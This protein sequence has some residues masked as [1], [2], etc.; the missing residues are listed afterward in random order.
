M[1]ADMPQHN[2]VAESLNR[3]LMEHV[4]AMQHQAGL[5]ATL[6][7]EA[8]NYAVWLKN[9]TSTK[10]LGNTMPYER[11]YRQ[12]PNLANLPDWGQ[13]VWVY[14]KGS[15]L[16]ARA[17]QAQWIGFD[18]DSTHVHRIYW[19]G[20]NKISVERDIKFVP[21]TVIVQTPALPSYVQATGQVAP[22]AAAAPPAPPAPPVPPAPA[23]VLQP[24]APQP[25]A[26]QPV[27]GPSMAPALPAPLWIPARPHSAPS[28]PG[29]MLGQLDVSTQTTPPPTP[30][31]PHHSSDEEHQENLKLLF[32]IPSFICDKGETS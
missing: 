3:R 24:P 10:I 16:D 22:Q 6:W 21:T 29:F 12:K 27:A 5:P 31:T 19:P 14:S 7:G 18:A 1:T 13:N 17:K 9:R 2:G 20:S 11:L 30:T 23:V 28:M 25:V 15:K 32:F 4:H 26:Q 8:I